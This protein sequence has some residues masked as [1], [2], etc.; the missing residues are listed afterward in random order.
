MQ[1][2]LS[3]FLLALWLLILPAC[4]S[5]I[6]TNQP[7]IDGPKI[8]QTIT[9]ESK[10]YDQLFDLNNFV[11]VKIHISEEEIAKIQDDYDKYTDLGTKSPIYRKADK[12]TVTIGDQVYEINDVGVRMKGNTSRTDFY[13]KNQGIYNIVNLKLSFDETFD[14]ESYY[15]EDAV[16]WSSDK[17]RKERKKRTFATLSGL[18]IKYNKSY[19]TTYLCE[20]YSFEIF[21][22]AGVLAARQKPV[23]LYVGDNC[24]GV[25]NIYEPVD[26]N[27]LKR[28]L[29]EEDL[30][31]DLYKAAWTMGPASYTKEVTYGI[32]N[33]D[34][35]KT[36]NYDLKTNKKKSNHESL[37]N[38]L[39]VLNSPD[40][41][42]ESFARVV[43][44]DYWVNFVAASY[45][46]G[47]PDDMRN[48]Y[49]NHFV[50]F[51]KSTGKAIFIP[52]DYNIAFGAV[53]SW[54]PT[55]TA[56]TSV[57]PY[58]DRAEGI[59]RS[60]KNP[61]FIQSNLYYKDEYTKALDKIASS[62][63]MKFETFKEKYDIVSSLY[64]D[65]VKPDINFNNLEEGRLNFS[66]Y[67]DYKETGNMSVE[68]YM[69]K[70][71]ESYEKAV[72]EYKN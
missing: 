28:Y 43:D 8:N 20:Y 55:R 23:V 34:E 51:L 68:E 2:K 66:L 59:N 26:E 17:E 72:A 38:L 58:S 1:R 65:Y 61:L 16:T 19:D 24:W 13:Y 60:Q 63:L 62:D 11:S 36:Y 31:G 67:S 33:P 9:D 30:G 37:S 46:T 6:K 50:Y 70:I 35:R 14:D 4:S 29:P 71:L 69:K 39:S 18:D 21:R 54:D 7:V 48:N 27:F 52:Y 56:M 32:N 64:K 40:H 10:L 53:S 22:E 44:V 47:N 3:L 57:S 5:D 12:V 49:N 15:D 41:S 25:C 42:K 45:F